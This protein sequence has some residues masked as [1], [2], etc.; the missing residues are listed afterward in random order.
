MIISH[1]LKYVFIHNPKTAGTSVRNLFVKNP[2]IFQTDVVGNWAGITEEQ[3][4]QFPKVSRDLWTHSSA[5]EIKEWMINNGYD[6]DD[7]F[8]FC[9]IRNPWDRMVSAY[10]YYMQTI[11]KFTITSDENKQIAKKYSKLPAK[12]FLIQRATDNAYMMYD[13][14]HNLLVDFVG[15]VENINED[16]QTIFKNIR[17]LLSGKTLEIPK[18]NTTQRV[19]NYREYYDDESIEV[20]RRK[21]QRTIKLGNYEF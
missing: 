6:W 14:N 8:K 3:F 1:R 20:V 4:E 11:P 15:K 16:M 17:P 18:D 13:A 12:D 5:A 10:E 9:F 7:Y 2:K 19:A 21:C